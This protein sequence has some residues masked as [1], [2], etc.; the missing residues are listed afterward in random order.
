MTKETNNPKR[1]IAVVIF[2]DNICRVRA[3][4]VKEAKKKYPDFSVNL[5]RGKW[6]CGEESYNIGKRRSLYNRRGDERPKEGIIGVFSYKNL[7]GLN[8]IITA[9]TT[10]TK[11]DNIICAD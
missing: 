10:A 5:K 8:L 9:I 1:K 4:S 3:V 11:S 7:E 2:A 6:N